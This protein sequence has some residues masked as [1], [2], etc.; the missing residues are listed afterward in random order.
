M[1]SKNYDFYVLIY[2]ISKKHNVGTLIRSASAF[3]VKKVLILGSDKKI[4]KKFFGHQ[5]TLKK[6]E[7]LF[8]DDIPSLK[9]FIKE[10]EIHVCGIEIGENS[11]PVHSQPFKGNT[12]FVLGNE[13]VGMNQKQKDLCDS[14][15]Y[16]PHYSNKTGSL[17][18]AI[19]A[20]IVFH[21][22]GVWAGYEEAEFTEE[23]YNV[24][25]GHNPNNIN[26]APTQMDNPSIDSAMEGEENKAFDLIKD[27][28][29]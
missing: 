2:N 6:T 18:V 27:I 12:L 25:E 26:T 14:Y 19:A 28:N 5:G 29:I 11:K 24:E 7:F 22:F 23:K 16:I 20:S 8:F 9:L 17:N 10:N 4:L 1:E 3:N 21:H 15:V 13:G